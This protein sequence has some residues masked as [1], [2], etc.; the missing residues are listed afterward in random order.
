MLWDPSI[1]SVTSVDD[2]LNVAQAS[3]EGIARQ[4]EPEG[5]RA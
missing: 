2:F 1:P 3:P 4:L 5:D